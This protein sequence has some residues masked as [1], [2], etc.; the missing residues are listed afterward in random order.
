MKGEVKVEMKTKMKIEMK[1]KIKEAWLDQGFQ[2]FGGG[3]RTVHGSWL[4]VQK[5]E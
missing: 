5:G 4:T 1:T 3:S 2:F